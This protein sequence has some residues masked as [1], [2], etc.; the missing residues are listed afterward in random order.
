MPATRP[1]GYPLPTASDLRELYDHQK[2]IQALNPELR[3][4]SSV[5]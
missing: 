3:R 5:Q 4:T 2:N 1:A